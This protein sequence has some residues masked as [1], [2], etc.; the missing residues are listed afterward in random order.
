M[1][2]PHIST[3]QI[4]A[5]LDVGLRRLI[6]QAAVLLSGLGSVQVLSFARNALI[7][8]ALAP[9]D[10]GVAATITLLL[11][12]VETLTDVGADRLIVQDR[13]GDDA[14]FV[15]TA[16]SLL[17]ARGLFLGALMYAAAAPMAHFFAV[18]AAA[19]AFALASLVPAIKGFLHL[20]CRRA[21][22]RMHNRPQMI[23]EVLPQAFALLLTIP[24]LA[25]APNYGAV[26]WLSVVQAIVSVTASHLIAER[27]Y[28]LAAERSALRRQFDFGWPILLSALPLIAV[29]Q[30]DRFIIAHASGMESLAAY[31]SAFMIT[32]VP[33]LIAA[34]VGHALM[35]PL[36]A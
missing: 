2:T 34:R 20:D 7:A 17:I 13:N 3:S 1:S 29:Y 27:P 22:R 4:A 25:Y 18:P 33:G 6:E 14:A 16:H 26:V 8:H 10:F 23:V 9:A 36:F 28:R 35:L 30:G 5:P 31:T 24:A 15:A 19:S 32:M 12:L 21:Q 11:Q